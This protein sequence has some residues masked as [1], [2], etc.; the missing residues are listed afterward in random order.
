M[1]RDISSINVKEGRLYFRGHDATT[2]ARQGSYEGVLHLLVKGRLPSAAQMTIVR[3]EMQR[4]KNSKGG[5]A[6]ALGAGAATGTEGLKALAAGLEDDGD[7]LYHSLLSFITLAP[8]IVCNSWRG[9]NGL[10]PVPP[11]PELGHAASLLRMMD[12]KPMQ[13]VDRQFETC[14]ILHMDDPDNPSLTALRE[15]IASGRSCS[16]VIQSA[17]EEHAKPLHHGAGFEAYRMLV[18][19]MKSGDVP[20]GMKA[21]IERG[22]R[23]FGLGHRI[24]R[25][26]DP[27]AIVL[28]D[29][30][31]ERARGT[32]HEQLLETIEV[33][34]QQGAE[35]LSRSKGR[36]FFPNVD[37][38]NA[39]V[40]TTFGLPP[41]F[42][43]DLFAV[44]RV[45][46]WMAH[47][48]EMKQKN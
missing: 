35:L 40:Y 20:A 5:N 41:E 42:N 4:V 29:I 23:V 2:L 33:V 25:T 34:A 12:I 24:Y 28:R 45:S 37:L 26:I 8:A 15:A 48:L 21:R 32:E 1:N 9:K 46:G 10:A 7:R 6:A 22:E 43:T 30:L 27:R 39:A 36:Q 13:G 44:S 47:I 11:I 3:N 38:Y 17:L 16:E 31:L 19:L 14:L 18:D